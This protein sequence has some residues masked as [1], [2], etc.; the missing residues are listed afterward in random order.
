MK[1]TDAGQIY[2]KRRFKI[3]CAGEGGGA[4]SINKLYK[5]RMKQTQST[6]SLTTLYFGVKI[7][8]SVLHVS[9]MFQSSSGSAIGTY[10]IQECIVFHVW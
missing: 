10:Q 5:C 3:W 9:A 8:K 1:Y 6:A 4:C 7:H 2:V